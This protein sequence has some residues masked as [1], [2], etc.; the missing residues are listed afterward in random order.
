MGAAH[1]DDLPYL[2]MNQPP[3]SYQGDS[4]TEDDLLIQK[5]M[6]RMWTNFA[7][8][9][10]PTPEDSQASM[11]LLITSDIVSGFYYSIILLCTV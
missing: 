5:R 2:F 3:D 9:G 7:K 4:W 6:L 11:L 8:T 10:N 1:T